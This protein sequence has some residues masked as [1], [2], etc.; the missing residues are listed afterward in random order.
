MLRISDQRKKLKREA[1]LTRNVKKAFLEAL[2]KLPLGDEPISNT[3]IYTLLLD[4]CQNLTTGQGSCFVAELLPNRQNFPEADVMQA[5][6]K[7]RAS[8]RQVIQHTAWVLRY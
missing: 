8:A 3:R 2:A 5:L 7:V 6:C 1:F 4:A